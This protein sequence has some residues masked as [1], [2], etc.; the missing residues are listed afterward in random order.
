MRGVERHREH[1]GRTGRHVLSCKYMDLQNY[2][3]DAKRCSEAV[4][5]HITAAIAQGDIMGAVNHW[6]AIKLEDG[7]SPDSNS[8]YDTKEQAVT[9]QSNP[10]HCCYIKITPDGMSVRDAASYLRIN[11]HPFIDTTAPEHKINPTIYPRFSNLTREQ[12][13]S[14]IEQERRRVA[15]SN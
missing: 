10:K 2:S 14:L 6:I 5:L 12:K 11:R 15:G 7:S 8:L 4:N 1:P 9:H 13:M 3:D